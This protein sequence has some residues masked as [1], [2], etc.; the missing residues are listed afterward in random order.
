VNAEER[1]KREDEIRDL[2]QWSNK[3]NREAVGFLLERLD[4][5]RA[6]E[7]E[8]CAAAL[9]KRA[10]ELR[11]KFGALDEAAGELNLQAIAIRARFFL[12]GAGPSIICHELLERLRKSEEAV[13]ERAGRIVLGLREELTEALEV[14]REI[15]RVPIDQENFCPL[16]WHLA[17]HGHA[18]TCRLAKAIAEWAEPIED[19]GET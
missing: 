16:C 3:F 17:E 1:Q 19:E 12:P 8:A 13:H 11:L 7:Q 5:A 18:P 4:L 2:A 14:L 10:D 15:E 9:E 6:E